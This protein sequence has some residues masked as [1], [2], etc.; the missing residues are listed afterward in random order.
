M[1]TNSEHKKVIGNILELFLKWKKCYR[2][3]K[4][5]ELED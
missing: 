5:H 1:K 2:N 4:G 3:A